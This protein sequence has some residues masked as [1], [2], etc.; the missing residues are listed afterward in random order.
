MQLKWV[1]LRCCILPISLC[2]SCGSG[3]RVAVHYGRKVNGT[4]PCSLHVQVSLVK[5]PSS[6]LLP[7]AVPPVF[8]LL[9][10]A[11]VCHSECWFVLPAKNAWGNK[12][13]THVRSPH[14]TW[15]LLFDHG[16]VPAKR[17]WMRLRLHIIS[18]QTITDPVTAK[19]GKT[20]KGNK[21]FQSITTRGSAQSLYCGVQSFQIPSVV[22]KVWLKTPLHYFT[23][24]KGP[25]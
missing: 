24:F 16:I 13:H 23:G 21:Q 10:C 8:K 5:T 22:V 17:I 4:N 18:M 3:G 7:T 9:M 6:K 25:Q 2:S 20:L 14:N 19:H 1:I 15:T 12:R 11:R